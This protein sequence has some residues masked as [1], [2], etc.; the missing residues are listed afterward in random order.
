MNLGRRARTAVRVGAVAASLALGAATL[1]SAPATAAPRTAAPAVRPA[2]A[3]PAAVSVSFLRR[4]IGFG[5]TVLVT[6]AHDGTGRLFF[7]DRVG[8]VLSWVPGQPRARL[9]LDL[10]SRVNSA[11]GEQ[12]L[13]GLT[14]YTDF[15]R[16]PLLWVSYTDSS[17]ALQVSRFLL[18]SYTAAAVSPS[19]EKPVIRIP[20]PTYRNHNAGMIAFGKDGYFYI[21]TGD[22][23]GAGDPFANA[24]NLRSLSGKILRVNAS[25]ACQTHLYCIPIDNPFIRVVGAKKEIWHY[26]LRNPWR[27]S[28]DPLTGAMWIGD[29]GQDRY[30]EVDASSMATSGR[31]FGWSCREANSVYNASRCRA[32]TYTAPVAV[33]AHPAAE[34]LIGGV[35]YR[36][37]LANPLYG[38]YLFGDYITGTLWTVPAP[39]GGTPAVA[40]HLTGITSIGTD[41]GGTIWATTLTGGV[42]SASGT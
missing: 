25:K 7:V 40:G 32:V 35:V 20:H 4:G 17:G 9:Y 24:Q 13:L 39:S 42:Y 28:F 5:Q 6:S 18:G 11:G 14:F 27:F 21:S 34:A 23:G 26:G 31:N 36:R 22:G 38:R 29:V 33:V 1:S 3:T 2:A 15:R 12:G 8:R 19:L 16:V 30:E 37:L 10:R 41:Q